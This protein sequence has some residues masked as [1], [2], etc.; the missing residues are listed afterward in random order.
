MKLC[1][2]LTGG[3]GS[4]KST[5]SAMFAELGAR[6]VDTDIISHQLTQSNGEA[7]PK[8]R[9]V[10]GSQLIDAQG[11]LDRKMMRELVYTDD[12]A[13]RRLENILHPL[14]L[15]HTRSQALSPTDSPFTLVVVPL[16]FESG[17]Y[18]D[19]LNRVIVVDCDETTQ[20]SRTMQRGNLDE[21]A[22]RSIMAQQLERSRR[23]LLADDIICNDGDLS[24]LRE[25]VTKLHSRLIKL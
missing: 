8:I 4:G 22:V 7:I 2:G 11:A 1:H 18:R 9:E 13:K 14:I 17:R 20:I 24:Y 15:A 10:F 19:W 6:I 21:D 5:V 23:L 25:Q 3:I 12:G 16:L